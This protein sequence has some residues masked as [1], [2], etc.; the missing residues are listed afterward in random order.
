MSFD[1]KAHTFTFGQ[2]TDVSFSGNNEKT[3][4]IILIGMA[5]TLTTIRKTVSFNLVVRNPC[6]DKE[7]LTIVQ[8]PLPTGLVY[9]LFDSPS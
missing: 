4:E 7:F 1:T 8:Q 9:T 5:G 6:I 2:M 3:Y